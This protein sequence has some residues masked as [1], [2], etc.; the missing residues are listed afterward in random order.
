M[1][2]HGHYWLGQRILEKR[3]VVGLA[4]PCYYVFYHELVKVERSIVPF[5][6]SV[7]L[8]EDR[9]KCLAADLTLSRSILIL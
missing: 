7:E 3:G 4:R 6:R 5:L 1:L 2:E 9:L 8:Q